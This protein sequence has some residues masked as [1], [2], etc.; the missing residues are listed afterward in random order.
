MSIPDYNTPGYRII[1]G[2]EAGRRRQAID[3][4]I[5]AVRSVFPSAEEVVLPTIERASVYDGIGGDDALKRMTRFSD[6][7]GRDLCLRPE[8]TNTCRLLART[9]W[10]SR[11]DVVVFYEARCFR[12]ERPQ[13][14]RWRE[15]TQFGLEILNP[16]KPDDAAF[17]LTATVKAWADQRGLDF[18]DGATR[19]L[20]YY[21]GL[22]FEV[23]N[24]ALGTASQV[25]GGGPYPEGVGCAWGVDR[26]AMETNE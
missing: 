11:R 3:A 2:D 22:G 21:S 15:F 18:R 25:C 12:G 8:G 16:R 20:G 19:G 23:H 17:L 6:D 7:S 5:C 4:L 1:T 10:K 13:R 9:V 24:P 26:L 14:G